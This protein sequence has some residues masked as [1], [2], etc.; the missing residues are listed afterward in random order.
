MQSDG[1]IRPWDSFWGTSLLL[2]RVKPAAIENLK[3]E[4]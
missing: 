3:L 2:L 4:T 1:D